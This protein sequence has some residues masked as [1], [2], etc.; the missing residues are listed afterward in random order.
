MGGSGAF[1]WSHCSLHG[2]SVS[3]GLLPPDRFQACDA[4]AQGAHLMGFFDLASLLAQA[5]LQELIPGFAELGAKLRGGK[6]TNLLNSHG[7]DG[8]GWA[9]SGGALADNE[10]AAERQLGVSQ[11]E[12]F[13]GDPGRHPGQF[14]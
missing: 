14:K 13:L 4:L 9:S 5:Q 1:N 10:T 12:G 3:P 6:F 7:S 11:P 8:G 2:L